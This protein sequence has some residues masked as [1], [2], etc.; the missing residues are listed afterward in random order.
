MGPCAGADYNLTLCLLQSRLQHIYH[1]Q[2]YARVDWTLCQSRLYPHSQGLRIWP[3]AS[4]AASSDTV[5]FTGAADDLVLN[6]VHKNYIKSTKKGTLYREG[7]KNESVGA[8]FWS[9]YNNYLVV[10]HPTNDHWSKC[11]EKNVYSS[12]IPSPWLRDIVDSGILLSYR[13]STPCSLAGR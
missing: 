10:P 9:N 11:R 1:R 12:Q 4:I 6:K 3:L 2:P 5:E 8:A 13:P 7:L